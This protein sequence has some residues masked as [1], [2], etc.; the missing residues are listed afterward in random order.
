MWMLSVTFYVRSPPLFIP[1]TSLPSVPFLMSCQIH[2]RLPA[3]A[4]FLCLSLTKCFWLSFAPYRSMLWSQGRLTRHT[5][6]ASFSSCSAVPL[7]TPS[8]HPES[9]S[10]P[11][12][13]IPFASTPTSIATARFAS[14]F[15]G[16]SGFVSL[17]WGWKAQSRRW[18]HPLTNCCT[19]S[20]DDIQL[21]F[22]ISSAVNS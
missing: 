15:W 13:T 21:V 20:E 12:A 10:S 19:I 1:T 17:I 9:S 14:V 4:L 5:R 22:L 2:P 16:K 18:Q 3:T 6:A 7:I 11:R 8:T